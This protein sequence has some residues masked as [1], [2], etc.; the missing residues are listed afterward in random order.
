MGF[1]VFRM[2]ENDSVVVVNMP[3]NVK[4]TQGVLVVIYKENIVVV[5]DFSKLVSSGVF[6]F[7]GIT[8]V[9]IL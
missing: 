4:G 7:K 6:D 1:S 9:N 2:V 5:D 3:L 8:V